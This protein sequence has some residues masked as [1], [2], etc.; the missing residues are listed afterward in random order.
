M[1]KKIIVKNNEFRVIPNTEEKTIKILMGHGYNGGVI[2]STPKAW[3]IE[4]NGNQKWF[5]KSLVTVEEVKQSWNLGG[6][7]TVMVMP[8]WLYKKNV[9]ER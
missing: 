5:P 2:S 1:E 3:L 6:N 7:Y 8:E 4:F 9:L